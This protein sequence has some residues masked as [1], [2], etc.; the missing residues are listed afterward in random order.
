MKSI[1]EKG[2]KLIVAYGQ[3]VKDTLLTEANSSF[4]VEYGY[5][6]APTYDD[7]VAYVTKLEKYAPA[8]KIKK[9][10]KVKV[11]KAAE[12]R[13]KYTP[14]YPKYTRPVR[15]GIYQVKTTTGWQYSYFARGQWHMPFTDPNASPGRMPSLLQ[16]RK[17]RGV[18]E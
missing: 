2:K 11:K 9:P 12:P 1:S 3:A 17:W 8:P 6:I 7:L 5:A 18:T 13:L 10:K 14:W 16:N 4:I 15:A